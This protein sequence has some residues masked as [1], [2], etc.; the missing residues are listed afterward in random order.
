MKVLKRRFGMTK[1]EVEENIR[2]IP[3]HS[4]HISIMTAIQ[5]IRSDKTKPSA[6]KL[7]MIEQLRQDLAAEWK[8]YNEVQ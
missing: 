7:R 3:Y 6:Q 1:E 5:L 2:L 4:R 8:K